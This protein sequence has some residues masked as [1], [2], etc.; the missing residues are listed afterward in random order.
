MCALYIACDHILWMWCSNIE[1]FVHV[2]GPSP[3]EILTAVVQRL[4]WGIFLGGDGQI[5][6]LCFG[7]IKLFFFHLKKKNIWKWLQNLQGTITYFVK[8]EACHISNRSSSHVAL[9]KMPHA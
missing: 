1:D 4:L 6:K 2:Y 8:A 5:T 7:C 9:L 3:L